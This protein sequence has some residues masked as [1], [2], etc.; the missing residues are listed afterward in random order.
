MPWK[1][2][3]CALL[4]VGGCLFE[5]D[6]SS[7]TYRCTDG[8]CPAGLV[9][10]ADDRCVA[11]TVVDAPRDGAPADVMVDARMAALTCI[12]PGVIPSAGGT[13]MDTTVGGISRVSSMCGGFV[14]NGA[15]DVYRINATANDQFLIAITGVRAYVITP[16][17]IT[18]STPLCLGGAFASE[19]NPIAVTTSFTGPYFV[20]VDHEAPATQAA[21]TLTVTRQ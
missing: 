4:L 5:A 1:P 18:P 10:S 9:C 15:D 16:C 8:R 19:G 12:D 20:V 14:M 21:Y 2:A 13:V 17:S 6:Y 11:S 3:L 7:G